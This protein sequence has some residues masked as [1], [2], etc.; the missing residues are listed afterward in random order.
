MVAMKHLTPLKNK[1]D[2]TIKHLLLIKNWS[3]EAFNASSSYSIASSLRA[4]D[5]GYW[6]HLIPNLNSSRSLILNLSILNLSDSDAKPV[7]FQTYLILNLSES[8]VSDW[9]YD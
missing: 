8:G 9:F 3:H 7:R 2:E 1:S 4:K 5:I 6:N